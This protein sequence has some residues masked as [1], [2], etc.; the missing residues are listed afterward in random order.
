MNED[1]SF[2]M[3]STAQPFLGFLPRC[4][5]VIGAWWKTRD[6]FIIRFISLSFIGVG[7]FSATYVSETRLRVF[8]WVSPAVTD[9]F[10][11]NAPCCLPTFSM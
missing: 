2:A 5:R 6:R 7:L 10:T 11:R 9:P 8:P 3:H 1:V 4:L